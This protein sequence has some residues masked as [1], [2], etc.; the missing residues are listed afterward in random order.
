[1]PKWLDDCKVSGES[2]EDVLWNGSMSTSLRQRRLLFRVVLYE[3]SRRK[4]TVDVAR[5]WV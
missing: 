1:M 5:R 4:E 3:E 2:S